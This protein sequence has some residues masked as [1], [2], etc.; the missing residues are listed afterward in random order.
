MTPFRM[1]PR[2]NPNELRV[3]SRRVESSEYR[4]DHEM[5]FGY[6]SPVYTTTVEYK[7]NEFRIKQVAY[8]DTT[9]ISSGYS[10]VHQL[11]GNDEAALE[12]ALEWIKQNG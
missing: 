5:S 3:T 2:N 1:N 4:R 11:K 6:N 9:T 8:P 7:G 10:N 12:R